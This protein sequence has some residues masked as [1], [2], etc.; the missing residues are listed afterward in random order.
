LAAKTREYPTHKIL[1]LADELTKT[2]V[3]LRTAEILYEF[4]NVSVETDV[5]VG[6]VAANDSGQSEL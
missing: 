1:A 4:D 6:S 5:E 3:A 2:V